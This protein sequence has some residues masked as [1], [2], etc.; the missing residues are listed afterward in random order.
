MKGY[1]QK[2]NML[3]PIDEEDEKMTKESIQ[4]FFHEARQHFELNFESK[5]RSE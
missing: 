1:H 4:E 3:L 2:P 5:L